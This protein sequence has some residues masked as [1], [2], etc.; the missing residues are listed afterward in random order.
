VFGRGAEA[1]LRTANRY[2][3]KLD[4]PNGIQWEAKHVA[5][6]IGQFCREVVFRRLV[7]GED[8]PALGQTQAWVQA[9]CAALLRLQRMTLERVLRV[10]W[11][12]DGK[13]DVLKAQRVIET[14][15]LGP[16]VI[17]GFARLLPN[18]SAPADSKAPAT[19]TTGAV[20]SAH[21]LNDALHAIIRDSIAPHT[22]DGR[23]SAAISSSTAATASAAPSTVATSSAAASVPTAS[24]TPAF[25]AQT[26][27]AP[28]AHA[29]T[30]LDAKHKDTAPTL[31]SSSSSALLTSS[32]TG[33]TRL[34]P[35]QLLLASP[36][37]LKALLDT[38][39][40]PLTICMQSISTATS[41]VERRLSEV[42]FRLVADVLRSYLP[43]EPALHTALWT[44]APT[45]SP[46]A[47]DAERTQ[48]AFRNLVAADTLLRTCRSLSAAERAHFLRRFRAVLHT[49]PELDPASLPNPKATELASVEELQPKRVVDLA[50]QMR[51]AVSYFST[52]SI[53]QTPVQPAPVLCA[54]FQR[55]AQ[56]WV[57]AV[58]MSQ[59]LRAGA[60]PIL[61]LAAS[62]AATA[63]PPV[64]LH[65]TGPD[66]PLCVEN[67]LLA[68]RWHTASLVFGV[69]T[70]SSADTNT[71]SASASAGSAG[72]RVP[73][74]SDVLREWQRAV[75]TN[76][77]AVGLYSAA[78]GKIGSLLTK[79]LKLQS[80]RSRPTKQSLSSGGIEYAAQGNLHLGYARWV[81]QEFKSL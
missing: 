73:V 18:S 67:A 43:P 47:E 74:R 32:L 80:G 31:A 70:G 58:G 37:E 63:S 78:A 29:A 48:N 53:S 1:L 22:D 71:A 56:E 5:G 75:R 52:P 38:Y 26:A 20:D 11:V 25:V 49:N 28:S 55:S 61:S 21:S 16:A 46:A 15:S 12:S 19:A 59:A 39:R 54:A 30:G 76:L 7:F 24:A 44:P 65:V 36:H 81:S 41:F 60:L 69:S 50:S 57:G 27:L 45:H 13:F 40:Y 64:Q 2:L 77:S 4:L 9:E 17:D 23:S 79:W 8:R 10:A 35:H 33:Q 66:L 34:S 14:E 72:V 42:N 3:E 51:R 6:F 68:I 62:L